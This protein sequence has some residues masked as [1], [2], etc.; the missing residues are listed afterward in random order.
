MYLKSRRFWLTATLIA[1]VCGISICV[2]LIIWNYIDLYVIP[3]QPSSSGAMPQDAEWVFMA[4][5]R[6]VSTPVIT[7]SL[8]ILRTPHS[9]LAIDAGTGKK[10]WETESISASDSKIVKLMI[11]PVIQ[12]DIVLVSEENSTVSAFSVLTGKRFWKSQELKANPNDIIFFDIESFTVNGDKAYVARSNWGVSAYDLSNGDL[13]WEVDVPNRTTSFVEADAKCVYLGAAGKIQCLNSD[14]GELIWEREF[15]APISQMYLD[16]DTLYVALIGE[17]IRLI[18]LDLDTFTVDWTIGNSDL[19][20]DELFTIIATNDY[21]YAGGKRLY[22]ISKRDGKI[23]WSSD[24]TG[25]L[26]TP[27][28]VDSVI[29]IRNIHHDLYWLDAITG[30]QIGGLKLQTNSPMN[31][32][33]DR[34]PAV[35]KDLLLVPFGDN[36]VFAYKLK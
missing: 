35:F 5:D 16:G 32:D 9:I 6:I 15:N 7:D 28:A 33:P 12:D 11:A 8:A 13:L 18:A 22:K 25:W 4:D 30:R 14:T 31:H 19:P 2:G 10:I 23:L 20:N 27:L 29:V 36:R 34:S 24:E 1:V 21:L 26:E 17:E 3:F